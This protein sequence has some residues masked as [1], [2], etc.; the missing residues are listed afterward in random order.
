MPCFPACQ[1]A[2]SGEK[3]LLY[4]EKFSPYGNHLLL[5]F[6][7]QEQFDRFRQLPLFE[8]F[9]SNSDSGSALLLENVT[10]GDSTLPQEGSVYKVPLEALLQGNWVS[11]YTTNGSPLNEEFFF[12]YQRRCHLPAGTFAEKIPLRKVRNPHPD[13]PE[14][15]AQTLYSLLPQQGP[16][17]KI[18]VIVKKVGQ[19]SWNE[20]LVD[21]HLQL[22]FDFGCSVYFSSH[23]CNT[24]LTGSSFD[25]HPCLIISHWDM[26]HYNLLKFLKEEK[27][28]NFRAA[29]IPPEFI[30]LT[31]QK[32]VEKLIRCHVP[33]YLI[34]PAAA[35]PGARYEMDLKADTSNFA[36]FCGKKS[37]SLNNS[38]LALSVRNKAQFAFLCADHAYPQLQSMIQN[39]LNVGMLQR[40]SLSGLSGRY[41]IVVPHHGGKAGRMP[42]NLF[43]NPSYPAGKALVS[44]GYN[45]YH[46]PLP[47]VQKAFTSH[48]FDWIS[49]DDPLYDEDADSIQL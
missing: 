34:S 30:S 25:D 17:E 35:T 1:P 20:I 11:P 8:G 44:T 12:A 23:Q 5:D 47:A 32:M 15:S 38:G 31:S 14:A 19:G 10:F 18:T 24:L 43:S 48:H 46:H 26:D 28:S 41:H 7:Y 9:D 49:T 42:H 13:I 36:L 33:L 3:I 45:H 2:R 4:V 37:R 40:I 27:L 22:V 39:R 16:T 6:V 29:C 21:N